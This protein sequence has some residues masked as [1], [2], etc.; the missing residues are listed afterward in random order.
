MYNT[1]VETPRL[2]ASYGNIIKY[3]KDKFSILNSKLSGFSSKGDARDICIIKTGE[4]Q[5]LLLVTN[6][7]EAL[8]IFKIIE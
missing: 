2:D 7:N 1:E 6:N 4:N 5:Q 3:E 8:N